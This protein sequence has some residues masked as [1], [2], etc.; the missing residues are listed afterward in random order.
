MIVFI[1]GTSSSGKTSIMKKFSPK[2]AKVSADDFRKQGHTRMMK[3]LK[4]KY[5]TPDEIEKF[6]KTN[7]FALMAISVKS[8]KYAVVEATGG[9]VLKHLPKKIT[10]VLL[11]TPIEDLAKHMNARKLIGEFRGNMVF[12]QFSEKYTKTENPSES[13]DKVSIKEFIKILKTIKWAFTSEKTLLEFA[14]KTFNA[15]GI[16]DDKK[17]HI[18][19]RKKHYDIVLM[20]DGKST[21]V[22]YN[23]LIKILVDEHGFLK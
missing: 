2:Y 8:K 22:L 15:M 21:Q 14:K 19:H 23:E 6:H 3:S 10:T 11:Y 4:N 7:R 17:H 16:D 9:G 13:I 5:Y 20:S 18:T 12:R 1:E